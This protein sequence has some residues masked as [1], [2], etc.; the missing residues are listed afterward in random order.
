M[1]FTGLNQ[2][3]SVNSMRRYNQVVAHLQM[4]VENRRQ[5]LV[6]FADPAFFCLAGDHKPKTDPL[7][8][9]GPG[10][11][12]SESISLFNKFGGFGPELG[13]EASFYSPDRKK[14]V[15]VHAE[16]VT[17]V[18][19]GKQYPTDFWLK[20]SAELGWAPDSSRF[21]LTWTDG[22]ETGGWHTQVYDV[23]SDGVHELKGIEDAPR[24][25][26]NQ[27]IRVLPIPKDELKG[28]PR[29][30]WDISQYCYP[31]VVGSQ[32]LNGSNEL[33]VSVLVPNLGDC[34]YMSE[35]NVYRVAI[36]SGQ[37]LQKYAAREAYKKFNLNNLPLITASYR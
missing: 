5:S 11:W 27:S 31:N 22:G 33:L 32:W 35:F 28:A 21:F 6:R 20:S 37:I 4:S 23:S 1:D 19:D 12:S 13:R 18:I 26:F 3:G 34:R 14:L 17:V 7:T 15:R 9:V 29:H 10:A 8:Y 36:P 25:D 2:P 24:K 16:A 30:F